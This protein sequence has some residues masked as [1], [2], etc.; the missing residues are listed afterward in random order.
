MPAH[1]LHSSEGGIR[2]DAI[3]GGLFSYSKELARYITCASTIHSYV[4]S[5]FGR[6][7]SLEAIKEMQA[8][9][10]A[11]RIAF[12]RTWESLGECASDAFS[13]R[14][15]APAKEAK[16]PEPPFIAP[17]LPSEIIA[18]IA[19]LY[20]CSTDDLVGTSRLRK[21]VLPRCMASYVLVERG[22]SLSQV[23]RRLN[24][25]HTSVRYL[26]LQFLKRATEEERFTADRYVG[27]RAA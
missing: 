19:G 1:S 24:R 5:R 23:G 4:K 22:N 12:R 3:N 10:K 6:A 27:R 15:A 25:D 13:Y 18:S 21:Y 26:R 9:H 17:I 16:A 8:T 20:G 2:E 11:A 7:P 14:P